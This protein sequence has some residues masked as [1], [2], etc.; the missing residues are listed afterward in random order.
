LVG[1]DGKHKAARD[2]FAPMSVL[3]LLSAV[4]VEHIPLSSGFRHRTAQAECEKSDDGP[5]KVTIGGFC[6]SMK[7]PNVSEINQ[8]RGRVGRVS[9][10]HERSSNPPSTPRVV[11]RGNRN[12][13]GQTNLGYEA[14]GSLAQPT[15]LNHTRRFCATTPK[16]RVV[17]DAT[18]MMSILVITGRGC[19]T[20]DG[21]R[22][23][24]RGCRG[25]RGRGCR[26]YLGSGRGS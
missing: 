13:P 12:R 18:I 1:L 8:S 7:F 23:W 2:P 5:F 20:Y 15:C 17:R 22:L 25:G 4:N 6:P 10:K 16:L 24:G 26:C 11:G 21:G 3:R 14:T 9:N 19:R